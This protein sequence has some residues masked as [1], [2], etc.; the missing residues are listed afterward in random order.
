[1]ISMKRILLALLI[2]ILAGA[3]SVYVVIVRPLV[4]P[5]AQ[6]FAAEA[7]LATPDLV[8]LAAVNVRQA[9]F[10]E[11]WFLG[12]PVIRAADSR[13]AR[14]VDE[15]TMLEH[16]TRAHVDVRRDV[17]HVV[18]GLYPATDRGVRHAIVVVGQFDAAAV[19][20]YLAGE[21]HGV[22]QSIAGRTSYEVRRANPDRCE[23]VTTWMITVDPRWI[24]I[25]DAGAHATLVP[26]LTQIPPADEAELAWWR[27]LAHS[28][29]VSVGMWRLRDADQTVS[30]PFLKTSARAMI[31]QAEGIEHVYLGLGA[32]TVPPS[33]RLRLVL[34]STDAS[35][36]RQKFADLRQSLQQSRDRWTQAAPSLGAL[37]DSIRITDNG[38]RETIEFTVDRTLASNLERAI[39]E[40]LAAVVSG[41]GGRMER[42]PRPAQQA[43]RIES[44][45]V[46]FTPVVDPSALAAYDPGA[47]FAEEVDQVQGPFGLRLAAMR[48]PST[49][50]SGLE[51]EVEAFAG[52]IP[53]ASA[54]GERARL[55][56]D[57]VTSVTGQELLRAEPC[58]RQRNAV[59]G[60]FS[61]WG[62][63]RL[64]A[65]KTVRLL[66]GAD[67]RMLGGIT[68]H[69]ELQLPTRV[70]TRSVARPAP[71]TTLAA[72]GAKVTIVKVEG[73][74]VQ[75]QVAGARDRVLE[76]RALNAAGQPL[77]S[78]MKV[79][80]DFLLGEGTAAQTQYAGIVDKLEVTF[81]AE[82]Q[83]LRW[84]FKLTDM[85][86]AGKPG[87]RM[88]DMTPDFRPYDLKALRR[89][90]PRGNPFELSFDRAQK[91]FTTKLDFTLRSQPLPNFERAFTVGR[92]SVKRIELKDGT[93]LT[94]SAAWDT[95]VR[96][97]SGVKDGMLTKS[98]YVLVD[99]KPSPESIKAV[100]GVLTLYFPR[101]L[102][103]VHLDDLFPGQ[104]ADVGGISVTVT[105]R[106]RRSLTLK[107]NQ[108][109]ERVIYV[110]VSD[111][112]G[113]PVMTFSP[114]VTES[115]DGA[116]RFELSPQGVAG[117]V[118]VIVAGELERKDYPFRLEPK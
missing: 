74:D 21:L 64:R 95:A 92:L 12:A 108:N 75:Y 34:D 44:Q 73:G 43:E 54:G 28:D 18:Y 49:A 41:L 9:V 102:R 35:R 20:R 97:G 96:F 67:P 107:T 101:T 63:Q 98:L 11:R 69:V 103:T 58:G 23:D 104:Q 84:P 37:F 118:D 26:R 99:A 112:D 31:A 14:P 50:D 86:M 3:V 113:Q 15:R 16:L 100:A 47:T 62:G 110:K 46:V 66:P 51:L 40:L 116:W 24:L 94:P 114:N 42:S 22:A 29:V 2:V 89:D 30:A 79:S 115:P 6:T 77:S 10:L 17:E 78:D 109:G 48:V 105:A 70:E 13:A 88:R 81:A 87:G 8:L 39:N 60:V 61:T 53:N 1:M 45:P 32:K 83:A 80:S 59:P 76:V 91:F 117:H 57:S 72:H 36:V 106:G 38:N 85:S 93:T 68:G 55:F 25:S 65:T 82:E 27:A 71:G 19:E 56:V 7:A 33:G 4:A 111:P 52:A 90:V 5:A